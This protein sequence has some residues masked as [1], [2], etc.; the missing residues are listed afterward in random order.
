MSVTRAGRVGL[1]LTAVQPLLVDATE[2]RQNPIRKV[3][4]LLQ[5]MQKKVEAEGEKA[6]ELY[7]KFMCYCQNSGGDLK[8]SI[9]AATA[10]IP[11]L[12]AS[13]E[14]GKSRKIQLE[15][16][17]K[18]HKVDRRAA[19]DAMAEATGI[20]DK[21]K[22]VFD[23]D[24]ADM[25]ANLAATRKATVAI[26]KGMDGAFLQTNAADVLRKVVNS[27]ESMTDADRG[28]VLAFLAGGQQGEYAPASAEIVGILKQMGDTMAADDKD[29]VAKETAAVKDFEALIKSKEKEVSTLTKSIETKTARVGELGVDIATMENDAGDTAEALS[30]DKKFG[31]DLKKNC[32][33]KTGIHEEEKKVRATEVVALADVIRILNDDS[34]LDLFKK[35]LPS[36]G[37]S[38]LQVQ[39]SSES[40][41][42]EAR[43]IVATARDQAKSGRHHLD[44]ILLALR[45]RKVGFDKIVNLID[46]MVVVMKREQ[47]DDDDKKAYC[48]KQLDDVEDQK[49]VLDQKIADDATVISDSK[50]GISKLT[51][52]LKALKTGII[53]LDKQVEEATAQRQAEAAEHKELMQSDTAAKELILFAKNRLNKFYNP[54][55]HKAAP[56]R[57]LSEGDQIYENEGGDIPTE[58]PGGIA[59]TGISAFVQ[60]AMHREAPPPPPATAAAYTKKA[61]GSSGVLAMMDLLVNDLDKEMTVAEVEEKNAQKEYEETITDAAEKRRLDSKTLTDKEGAKAELEGALERSKGAKKAAS[62][63]LMGVEKSMFSLHGECDWLLQN[64][65]AR[66]EARSDEIDALGKAKAVLS[67]ADYSLLEVSRTHRLSR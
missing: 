28:D 49:K 32:A 38:F 40:V 53:A 26:E 63:E 4:N 27:R 9:E 16:D 60:T 29:L 19:K 7:K 37:S 3:V 35:T 44:F 12:A 54:S 22:A 34:A 23:K 13:I 8:A 2:S 20:R 33:E 21:E 51:E 43:S 1:L 10:K 36:A 41:R 42:V 31:K 5:A 58:A 18:M 24:H 52:E 46:E 6:E 62:K 59:D 67:G 45:G 25:T 64:Y 14:A 47:G 56:K 17:L 66:K 61:E 50:E 48:E 65:G 39:R 30:E 55:Q 15:S 11:E 57:Q